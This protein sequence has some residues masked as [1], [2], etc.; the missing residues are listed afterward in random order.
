MRLDKTR[1]ETERLFQLLDSIGWLF[2]FKSNLTRQCVS[3][4]VIWIKPDAFRNSLPGR[5][6]VFGSRRSCGVGEIVIR[7]R[8]CFSQG[9]RCTDRPQ[10]LRDFGGR[11]GWCISAPH[12]EARNLHCC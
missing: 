6:R 8:S 12:V 5:F 1:P 11:P 4:S 7:L 3:P 2:G 9:N 10:I